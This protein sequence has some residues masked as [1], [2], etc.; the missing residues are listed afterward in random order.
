MTTIPQEP[1][2]D[3][4][5]SPV[6]G[7]PAT[8]RIRMR[9]QLDL[10]SVTAVRACFEEVLRHHPRRIVVEVADL[11]FMDST[12]IALL[13]EVAREVDSLELEH[14]SEIVR[15]VIEA[16]GLTELLRVVS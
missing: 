1:G 15:S 6:E 14:P 3:A 4:T 5:A 12:G 8:W 16:T 2:A 9:G 11:G 7:D 10:A 13:L